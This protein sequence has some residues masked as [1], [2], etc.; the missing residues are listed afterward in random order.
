MA[1]RT[2]RPHARPNPFTR[3]HLYTLARHVTLT[4]VGEAL[5]TLLGMPLWLRVAAEV[6][7]AAALVWWEVSS[8]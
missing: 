4:V 7:A 1:P 8:P 2:T 6:A 3:R 5:L